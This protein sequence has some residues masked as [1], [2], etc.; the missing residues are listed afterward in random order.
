M[1]FKDFV[2]SPAEVF[3]N[4]Y[5]ERRHRF[6]AVLLKYLQNSHNQMPQK[7]VRNNIGPTLQVRLPFFLHFT[8][9]NKLLHELEV[10]FIYLVTVAAKSSDD[11]GA[12]YTSAI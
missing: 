11:K 7:A 2:F 8:A 4:K 9:L 10:K 12:R 5:D 1:I 3:P 6:E